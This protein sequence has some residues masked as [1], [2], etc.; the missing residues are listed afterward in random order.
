MKIF[1]MLFFTVAV[2]AGWWDAFS[3]V[4][5]DASHTVTDTVSGVV[6]HFRPNVFFHKF[7]QQADNYAALEKAH[8]YNKDLYRLNEYPASIEVEWA[9]HS[10]CFWRCY[11]KFYEWQYAPAGQPDHKYMV[12]VAEDVEAPDYFNTLGYQGML[13]FGIYTFE[14]YGANAIAFV[15][16]PS[17]WQIYQHRF[18][19]SSLNKMVGGV[20]KGIVSGT[21]SA[22]AGAAAG[23]AIGSVI[24][25]AGTA[26][27]IVAGATAGFAFAEIQD[28]YVGHFLRHLG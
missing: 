20:A 2:N 26:V 1:K 3:H 27:G 24:P 5:E 22:A 16:M 6:T 4:F 9:Q 13:N 14:N 10:R 8:A 12:F 15:I 21:A 19:T 25:V 7:F 28:D 11:A 18:K 17:D 23:A